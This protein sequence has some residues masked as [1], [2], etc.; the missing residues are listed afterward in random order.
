MPRITPG[1]VR[2][3]GRIHEQPVP[4]LQRMRVPLAIH[5]A[6]YR[7]AQLALKGGRNRNLLLTILEKNRPTPLLSHLCPLPPGR[8]QGRG[9]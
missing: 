7:Q 2:Y 1:G 3:H 9:R 4:D 8:L 6:G 5:L